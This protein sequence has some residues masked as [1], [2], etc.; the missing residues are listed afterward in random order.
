VVRHD[1][2]WTEAESIAALTAGHDL[3]RAVVNARAFAREEQLVAEL[4]RLDQYRTQLIATITHEMKN[5]IGAI[6]G[7]L[8]LIDM[9]LEDGR[10]VPEPVARSLA[11]M[12]RSVQR[13]SS[14]A[15]SLLELTRLGQSSAPV[16][17]RPVVMDALAGEVV[18]TFET[19]ARRFGVELTFDADDD[20][21][22]TG[23][24]G[25]LEMLLTN[26]VSN[27]VKY[28]DRGG[29]AELAVRRDG[30]RALITCSDTGIGISESDQLLVFGE[31]HRSGDPRARQRPGSGLG[32]AIAH[33]I[34][35]RHRGTISVRSEQ[36][37]GTVFT[38]V[39]PIAEPDDHLDLG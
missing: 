4:Q 21:V 19:D 7:H 18:H 39:L 31:F 16:V 12:T 34:V 30:E 37:R 5:P 15:A 11:S 38:V 1:L 9:Q 20:V 36:G 3:G 8:E 6:A 29:S 35:E 25:E 32:L 23:D 2:R 28:T 13:L 14:L 17:S 33:R 24:A 26:L 22:V 10:P 27:A